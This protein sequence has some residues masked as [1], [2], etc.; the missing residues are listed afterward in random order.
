M[1]DKKVIEDGDSKNKLIILTMIENYITL[2]G[3]VLVVLYAPGW[4]KLIS[5][6]LLLNLNYFKNKK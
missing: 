4:W 5:I 3:I 2:T 6:G 1:A